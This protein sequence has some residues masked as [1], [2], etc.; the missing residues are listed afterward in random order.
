MQIASRS[1]VGKYSIG[2]SVAVQ[3]IT[4]SDIMDTADVAITE[5]LDTIMRVIYT[6][7]YDI[8]LKKIVSFK[9]EY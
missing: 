5:Q 7:K 1:M 8:K 6:I 4:E 9:K 3:H 2:I